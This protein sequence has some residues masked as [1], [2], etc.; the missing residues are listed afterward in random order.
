MFDEGTGE[1]DFLPPDNESYTRITLN[2]FMLFLDRCEAYVK[3]D[4]LKLKKFKIEVE[5]RL[6]LRSRE[7][8]VIQSGRNQNPRGYVNSVHINPDLD[9]NNNPIRSKHIP[10]SQLR[11]RQKPKRPINKHSKGC[12]CCHD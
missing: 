10:F 12:R 9:H 3:G 11:P 4:T 7:E 8:I 5:D 1:G 6:S 2:E